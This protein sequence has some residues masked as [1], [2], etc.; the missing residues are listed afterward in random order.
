MKICIIAEGSYPYI[1][2]GVSTWIHRLVQEM[3]EHDFEILSLVPDPETYPNYKYDLPPMIK[4]VTTN[5]LN[6]YLNLKH[7]RFIFEPRLS[8]EGKA[9]I[10]DFIF[11]NDDIDWD[12]FTHSISDKKKIG[13]TL[14][15]LQTKLFWEL[16]RRKYLEEYNTHEFNAFFWT[17]RSMLLPV[18]HLMQYPI[19][20]ADIYHSVSTGYAG[21]IGLMAKAKYNKPL[22]LTEHGIY[23]RER[24][25]DILKSRWLMQTYKKL[26]TDFFYF[27]STGVYKRA[28]DI[29]TLF[30]RNHEIQLELGAP[31]ERCQIIPNGIEPSKY[32]VQP[33][34]EGRM[35][36]GSILRV[37]PIKD[38]LTLIRAF[39]LVSNAEPKAK[40]FLIGPTD[41]DEDYYEQCQNL[42]SILDLED[43][44]TFTG[45]ID[46]H[47]ILPKIDV[48]ALTSISEGMPLV[49]LEG[50]A[51]GIPFVA[52]NVGSCKELLE[53]TNDDYGQAGLIV[54]P[55]SPNKIA[56]SLLDLLHNPQKR[57]E[58]AKNGRVRVENLYSNKMLTQAY[59][60]IYDKYR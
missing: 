51:S 35:N 47:D 29:V 36:I 44:I 42:V 14:N 54:P 4:K 41:E 37:V 10:N 49:I 52:T 39:K 59:K 20:E 31:K 46:I 28:D 55:V 24:E 56:M 3:P 22:I 38:V 60:G 26:W 19:P 40:L 12:V 43:V 13:N 21:L 7:K 15:F 2:G 33:V 8:K 16:I 57:A 45:R 6:T 32:K 30:H 48:L 9:S 11:F 18:V 58:F 1:S 25:E 17:I 50:L 27:I 23:A 5:Y 34:V 53:G